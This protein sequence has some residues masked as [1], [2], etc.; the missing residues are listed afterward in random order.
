M[1]FLAL[2]TS[3]IQPRDKYISGPIHIRHYAKYFMPALL[4]PHHRKNKLLI[5]FLHTGKFW[6]LQFLTGR[7]IPI[8][9]PLFA[10]AYLIGDKAD[11]RPLPPCLLHLA[12]DL[13]KKGRPLFFGY[14]RYCLPKLLRHITT[15]R[16]LYPP[17][18][19]IAL[20]ITIPKKIVLISRC[21]RT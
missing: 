6:L 5:A 18:S 21:V 14:F 4:H 15:N 1:R 13:R 3:L 8:R 11:F 2:T 20:F 16:K 12:V 19:L 7:K 9:Q 10:M 17:K